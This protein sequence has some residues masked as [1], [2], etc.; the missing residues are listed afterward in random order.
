ARRR[1]RRGGYLKQEPGE[2]SVERVEKKKE[3]VE[4]RQGKSSG[5][6]CVL[7]FPSICWGE[8]YFYRKMRIGEQVL[9]F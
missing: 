8:R 4:L 7:L 3:E 9:L 6:F 1:F 2:E 5:V